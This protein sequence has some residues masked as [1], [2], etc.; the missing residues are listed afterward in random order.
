MVLY[1]PRSRDYLIFDGG[2]VL[3]IVDPCWHTCRSV[4]VDLLCLD[5]L[6]IIILG[7]LFSLNDNI[8][9]SG[10]YS[11]CAVDWLYNDCFHGIVSALMRGGIDQ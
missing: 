2:R 5:L 4:H 3:E 11:L 10:Q 1:E 8:I 7:K 6:I 9:V